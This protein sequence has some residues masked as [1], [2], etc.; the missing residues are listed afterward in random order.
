MKVLIG[1]SICLCNLKNYFYERATEKRKTSE[2][3]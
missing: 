3:K 2:K 1:Q